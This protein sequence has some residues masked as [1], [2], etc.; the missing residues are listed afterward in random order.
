MNNHGK[1]YFESF[2][3]DNTTVYV[4]CDWDGGEPMIMNPPDQGHPG[5]E[6]NIEI[7]AVTMGVGEDNILCNLNDAYIKRL[8]AE[9]WKSMKDAA[10]PDEDAGDYREPEGW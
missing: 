9:A 4:E 8:E 7:T 3:G 2:I 1:Y 10:E 6:P 5:C